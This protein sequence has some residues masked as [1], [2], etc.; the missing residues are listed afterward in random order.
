LLT[1]VLGATA[2]PVEAAPAGAVHWDEELLALYRLARTWNDKLR[3]LVAGS[4]T[5]ALREQTVRET[6]ESFGQL[7]AA[8][9]GASGRAW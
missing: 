3:S 4:D 1:P 5:S 9:A 2:Q 6:A 7:R 8:I